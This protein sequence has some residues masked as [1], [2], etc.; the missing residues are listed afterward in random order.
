MLLC[1]TGLVIPTYRKTSARKE[2]NEGRVAE[3]LNPCKILLVGHEVILHSDV[4]DY[5]RLRYAPTSLT[6]ED[7]CIM[8]GLDF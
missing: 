5:S 7:E 3:C 4:V 1:V 6:L 8:T 2:D